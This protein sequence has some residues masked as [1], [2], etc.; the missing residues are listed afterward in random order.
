MSTIRVGLI[1]FGLSGRIFHGPFI[2]ANADMTL[3]CVS[4]RRP[5]EVKAFVPNAR[6]VSSPEVLIADEEI[7]LV[8]IT[9]PNKVHFSLAKASLLA[10]KH[11]LLEKPSVTNLSDIEALCSLAKSKGLVLSVYQN[12]RYDSDFLRL[13]E[14][15]E[16]SVLGDV[17]YIESRFDRFRPNVQDRW[18]ELPGEGTG[19]FWDLGPHLLD[20]MLCLLGEPLWLQG[21]MKTLRE[22]SVTTD[23]FSVDM[24]YKDKVVTIGSSPFEAGEVLR[25]KVNASAGSWHCSGLDPQEE[26]LRAGQMPRDECFPSKGQPQEAF[27]YQSDENGVITKIEDTMALGL[28]CDFYKTLSDSILGK[29]DA[30]VSL[31]DA[32]KV[33]YGLCLAEQSSTE[34]KRL[35]WDYIPPI[36]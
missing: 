27:S 26:A 2:L 34:G 25:F 31:E 14:L 17:K 7:D 10:G 16:G 3:E 11:V 5:D 35:N 4:S 23:F 22:G 6:V 21:N 9:S 29:G 18:R 1:G 32:C 33:I 8:V 20:Q 36:G 28:Y 19:I 24:G 13:R 12:R 30:P 15:V